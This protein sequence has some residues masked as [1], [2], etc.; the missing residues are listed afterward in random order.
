MYIRGPWLEKL[1]GT[2]FLMD[3]ENSAIPGGTEAEFLI[4]VHDDMTL[5]L[6]KR[7]CGRL[8]Y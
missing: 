3:T 5:L 2:V 7:Y 1:N 8:T 4:F 6:S